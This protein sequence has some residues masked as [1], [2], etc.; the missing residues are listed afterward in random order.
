MTMEYILFIY[1][2]VI[3]PHVESKSYVSLVIFCCES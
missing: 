3:N 2:F 1:R